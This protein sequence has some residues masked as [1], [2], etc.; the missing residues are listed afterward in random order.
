ML[1]VVRWDKS[2]GAF[3]FIFGQVLYESG[4]T[5]PKQLAFPS[6]SCDPIE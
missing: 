2:Y 4:Q 5:M 6:D 3:L 1:G